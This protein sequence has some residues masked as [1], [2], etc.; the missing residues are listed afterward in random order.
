MIGIPLFTVENTCKEGQG[1]NQ[2]RFLARLTKTPA[3]SVCLKNDPTFRKVVD[4]EVN[5][6]SRRFQEINS[7]NPNGVPFGDNCN[8]YMRNAMTYGG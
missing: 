1:G 7:E 3:V 6:F 2:C 5:A 8:G 4:G